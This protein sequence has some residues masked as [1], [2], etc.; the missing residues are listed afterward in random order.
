[1][2][3]V[4]EAAPRARRTGLA[5]TPGWAGVGADLRRSWAQLASGCRSSLL[6]VFMPRVWARITVDP[7]LHPAPSPSRPHQGRHQDHVAGGRRPLGAR[8]RRLLAQDLLDAGD[9]LVDRLVG[10][11]VIS[12]DAVDRLRPQELLPIGNLLNVIRPNA[13]CRHVVCPLL[14]IGGGQCFHPRSTEGN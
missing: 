7:S 6:S 1:M 2:L 4:S 11:D 8:D 5:F 3:V 12:G 10:C 9:G 14:E 13:S